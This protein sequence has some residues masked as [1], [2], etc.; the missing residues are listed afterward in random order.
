MPDSWEDSLAPAKSDKPRFAHAAALAVAKELV[1]VMRPHCRRIIV[2]GSLRRRKP[3]VGDV[4]ILFVPSARPEPVVREDMFAEP[5]FLPA[6]DAVIESMLARGVIVK[7][8]NIIGGTS[9]G[10]KNKLAIHC[11]T[12]IPVDLFATTDAAWWNY[13]V[14]RTGGAESNVAVCLAAQRKG[15][16]WN[17]YDEGFSERSGLARKVHPVTSEREVFELVGLEYREPWERF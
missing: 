11:A 8:P 7:R 12:G 5:E 16:K 15:W 9:W 2:A 1:E 6:T 10:M 17:P 3:D 13:L 4:E 14:C